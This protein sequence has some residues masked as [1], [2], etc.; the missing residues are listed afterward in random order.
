SG[1]Q[2]LPKITSNVSVWPTEPESDPLGDWLASCRKLKETA[3]GEVLVL[4]AHN[5]PFHGFHV[6]LQRLI[7]GHEQS[8]V[9]LVETLDEP[10]RVVDLFTALFKREIK[11]GL[12]QM[13]TGETVAHLNHL[14]RRGEVVRRM[15][16]AGVAW[17]ARS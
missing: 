11:G 15:D 5:T 14:R 1:D 7:D 10:R 16:E 12:L 13:A 4:P 17:Y 3:P 9:R 2:V 8:L 6:R